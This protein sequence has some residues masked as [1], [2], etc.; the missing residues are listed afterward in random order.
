MASSFKQ[1]GYP[2]NSPCVCCSVV[3]VGEPKY[4]SLLGRKCKKEKTVDHLKSLLKD[5]ILVENLILRNNPNIRGP[6][7]VL[8]ICG[9]C[10][11]KLNRA[12]EFYVKSVNALNC[13]LQNEETFTTSPVIQSI[14]SDIE[15]TTSP[16]CV[17]CMTILDLKSIPLCGKK[18]E[19]DDA[20]T[21]L[22]WFF[23]RPEYV[24]YLLSGAPRICNSCY[25]K[26]IKWHNFYLKTLAAVNDYLSKTNPLDVRKN[27]VSVEGTSSDSGD[28]VCTEEDKVSQ[29]GP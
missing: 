20:I 25:N 24:D 22:K 23:G 4:F 15:V 19:K 7:G 1:K 14:S 18:S 16:P 13:S 8:K 26:L 3:P 5:P 11:N 29:V 27:S 12:H 28:K 10:C 21:K 9:A 2:E 6:F 17:C